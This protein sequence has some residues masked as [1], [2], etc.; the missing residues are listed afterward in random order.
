MQ[1]SS[2][3]TPM[4][5]RSLRD[6]V[7]ELLS[8]A[9]MSGRIQPGER[10]NESHLARQLQVSRAPIREALQQL[11][12][13]GLVVNQPRRGMF[14]VSLDEEDLQKINSLRLVLETEALCLAARN[15]NPA[16]ERK[17]TQLV[18][19]MENTQPSPALQATRMDLEFHRTV[20]SLTGNEY[21]E[22]TLVSLTAPLFA[23]AILTKPK[24]EKLRMILDS[25]RPVLEFVQGK[26][27]ESA[28]QVMLNHLKL[29][30]SEPSKYASSQHA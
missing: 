4:A 12:E 13:Q 22:K 8:D 29:R 1:K 2:I 30:W 23:Y 26:S 20:W 15:L 16:G 24:N 17:L 7:A 25:H 9:L 10:L 6:S 21:L 18:E 14:V 28:Y 3:F 11:Q 19:K 5:S 27:S